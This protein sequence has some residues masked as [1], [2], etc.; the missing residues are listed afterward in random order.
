MGN[1]ANES[2]DLIVTSPPYPMI[3]MWDDLFILQNPQIKEA[4][5]S[6]NGTLAFNLM[7]E[8]LSKVWSECYRVL[9]K[10]G[11]A[12]INIGDTTRTIG[13]K[14][15][16][17]PSHAK[18]VSSCTRIGFQSLP[19]I[20]WRKQTNSPTKFM[21][22]GMLPAGAYVTL[23][24]EYILL[25]RKIGKREFKTEEEK[26]NRKKSAIFWEERN[27]WFSDVW[28][29]IKGDRQSLSSDEIRSRSA[30][31]P[32]D[33]SARLINMFSVQG[34]LILDPYLGT[35]TTILSAIASGRNSIGIELNE[36]FGDHITQRIID[37]SD[38][39][40]N[41]SQ[42]RLQNHLDFVKMAE[43]NGKQFKHINTNYSFPVMTKQEIDLLLPTILKI[44]T[45][46][47][48]LHTAT[49]LDRKR[50]LPME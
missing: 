21:G 23:E 33:I 42:L 30:A 25:F 2:V 50:F 38:V 1:I 36:S 5:A 10:G 15:K 14:F 11:Y 24:H 48:C 18:I 6:Q 34:D 9:K 13:S 39:L 45:E 28:S 27:Q 47:H 31:Y 20:I 29:D 19:G 46:N 40:K 16:L 17:Y 3:E 12:C 7:H 4:L 44:H 32:F 26:K 37:A 43:K 8:E 35:G 22:S 41:H 49:Y